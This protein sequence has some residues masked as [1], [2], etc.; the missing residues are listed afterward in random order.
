M[1]YFFIYILTKASM[2]KPILMSRFQVS[3]ASYKVETDS[4]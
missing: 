2:I 1:K 4:A 3:G